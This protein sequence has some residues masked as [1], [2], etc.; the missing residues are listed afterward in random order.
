MKY[1]NKRL[2]KNEIIEKLEEIYEHTQLD[3][4][5]FLELFPDS[6]EVLEN[7]NNLLVASIL[8]MVAGEIK[9]L[10]EDV[11]NV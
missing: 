2:T 4:E 1:T 5:G 6:G 3:Q 8:G 11:K 10:L 9:I 7:N